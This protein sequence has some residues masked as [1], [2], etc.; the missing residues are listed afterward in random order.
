VPAGT[1]K[2]R[3]R[4]WSVMDC[5]GALWSAV[6]RRGVPGS[7]VTCQG[8]LESTGECPECHGMPW[9]ACLVELGECDV[10]WRA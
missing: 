10:W 9:T 1:V 7:A 6:E 4:P 8:V 5:W 3:G 2:C